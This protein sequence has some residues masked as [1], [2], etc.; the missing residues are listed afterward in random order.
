MHVSRTIRIDHKVDNQGELDS[1][2]EFINT[3]SDLI[4]H[5]P[6]EVTVDSPVNVDINGE[7]L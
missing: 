1:F 3:L 6:Y 7:Q 5:T 4:N 2:H